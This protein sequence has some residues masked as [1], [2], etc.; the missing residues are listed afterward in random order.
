MHVERE[1]WEGKGSM[2]GNGGN[3]NRKYYS[4]DNKIIKSS[5]L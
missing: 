3:D 2:S 5:Y 1:L 4:C